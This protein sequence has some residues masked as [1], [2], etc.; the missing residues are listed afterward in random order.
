MSTRPP[1]T[2]ADSVYFETCVHIFSRTN[3]I[4]SNTIQCGFKGDEYVS[5]WHIIMSQMIRWFGVHFTMSEIESAIYNSL[6]YLMSHSKWCM[7]NSLVFHMFYMVKSN[8]K[9]ELPEIKNMMKL[10]L[11]RAISRDQ[12]STSN[13]PSPTCNICNKKGDLTKNCF[14]TKTCFKCNIKGHIAKFLSDGS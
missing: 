14:T 2:G 12:N 13:S 5:A 8:Q 6:L 10:L 3:L 11:Q 4:R 9:S 7:F 1:L